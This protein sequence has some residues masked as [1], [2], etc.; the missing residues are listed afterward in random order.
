MPGW[1]LKWADAT[2]AAQSHGLRQAL[3][4]DSSANH[5]ALQFGA[6]SGCVPVAAPQMQ[7]L[8]PGAVL[9]VPNRQRS[10]ADHTPQVHAMPEDRPFCNLSLVTAYWDGPPVPVL[11]LAIRENLRLGRFTRPIV[12]TTLPFR[13]PRRGESWPLLQVLA[14]TPSAVSSFTGPPR[15]GAAMA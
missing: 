8:P 7:T 14:D 2:L 13:T 15:R 11:V 5:I 12:Q 6:W 10:N 4:R 3:A 9:Y 1:N